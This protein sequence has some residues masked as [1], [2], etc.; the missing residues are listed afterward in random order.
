MVAQRLSQKAPVKNIVKKQRGIAA[1][2]PRTRFF[3]WVMREDT[4]VSMASSPCTWPMHAQGLDI[5]VRRKGSSTKPQ[6]PIQPK[7]VKDQD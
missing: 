4:A 2:R 1:A 3:C 5:Q 7:R 6:F